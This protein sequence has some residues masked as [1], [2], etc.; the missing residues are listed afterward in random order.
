MPQAR[1]VTA[2]HLIGKA[3]HTQYNEIADEPLPQRWVDLIHYLEEKERKEREAAQ[4]RTARS[5][6][7]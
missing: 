3:L 1:D 4:A 5:E 7:R 6:E 2:R